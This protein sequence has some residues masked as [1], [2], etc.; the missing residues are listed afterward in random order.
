M[1]AYNYLDYVYYY[2]YITSG[3]S[4]HINPYYRFFSFIRSID[5]VIH[6]L[7]LKLKEM[8]VNKHTFPCPNYQVPINSYGSSNF[9]KL[10]F[11]TNFKHI[12]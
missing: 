4:N 6:F 11:I 8:M 1:R 10:F 9:L 3:I 12:L 2:Y 7:Y 5:I